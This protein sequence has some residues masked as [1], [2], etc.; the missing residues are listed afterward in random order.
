ME[1]QDIS[2]QQISEYR[3]SHY[4]WARDYFNALVERSPPQAVGI[5]NSTGVTISK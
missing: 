4:I 1:L 5:P 3:N 2:T